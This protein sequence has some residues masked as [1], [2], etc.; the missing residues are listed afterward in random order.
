MFE[1]CEFSIKVEDCTPNIM[2]KSK[3]KKDFC[4]FALVNGWMSNTILLQRLSMHLKLE[5]QVSNLIFSS[6]LHLFLQLT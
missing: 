6:V 3:K 5:T 1:L 4:L 2:L